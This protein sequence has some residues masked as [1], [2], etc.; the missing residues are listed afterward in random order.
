MYRNPENN[1]RRRR[2]KPI[3]GYEIRV[4]GYLECTAFE[5][6]GAVSIAKQED[7]DTLVT[8]SIPDQAALMRVLLHLNDLGLTILSVKALRRRR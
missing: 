7:G 1:P 4:A 5:W 6:F 8:G 3:Q 2:S